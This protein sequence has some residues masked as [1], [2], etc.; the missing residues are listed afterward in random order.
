MGERVF[1]DVGVSGSCQVMARVVDW[2]ETLTGFRLMRLSAIAE[3]DAE[4]GFEYDGYASTTAFLVHRCGMGG[5]E[6][7]REVFLARSLEH[8]PYAVK[9]AYAGHISLT[10]LEL[11]AHARSKHP[12]P[13]VG[14]ETMLVEAISDLTVAKTRYVLDLWCQLHDDPDDPADPE[15]SRVFFSQTM[16]GRWR[17]DGDLSPV[18]GRTLHT[19]LDQ[20]MCEIVCTTPKHEL[21]A[22]SHRRAQ[23]LEQLARSYLDSARARTDHGNRP[24]LTAVIDWKT[25]T[26]RTRAGDSELLDGT[27]ITPEAARQLACDAI[28]C[29]LIIG[30]RGEILDLGR[31]TRTVTPAQW[32]VLRLRDR[33]CRWPGCQRPAPWCDAHHIQHWAN[34]GPTDLDNLILLCRHHHTLTHQAGWTIT[35]TPKDLRVARPDQTTLA[36]APP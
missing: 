5:G 28:V 17:L 24:H 14:D 16:D 10:Q 13:F 12:E 1:D 19:A 22:A 2:D 7:K 20:L 11:L 21:P 8:M 9:S 33:H 18:V 27:A 23:A 35:G 36:N 32:K 30:P 25:L 4:R 31:N 29:R 34:G 26:G 6:A 3:L 15:P